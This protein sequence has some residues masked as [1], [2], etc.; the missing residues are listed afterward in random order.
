MVDH[1]PLSLSQHVQQLDLIAASGR[2]NSTAALQVSVEEVMAP[3]LQ[4]TCKDLTFS[5][6]AFQQKDPRRG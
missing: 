1:V 5:F 6:S 4:K 2:I 3:P